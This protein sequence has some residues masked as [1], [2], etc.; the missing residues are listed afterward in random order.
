[1]LKDALE[2]NIKQAVEPHTPVMKL[3]VKGA[4]TITN[5]FSVDQGGKAPMEKARRSSANRNG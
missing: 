2:A 3:M 4:A 1:M 5:R